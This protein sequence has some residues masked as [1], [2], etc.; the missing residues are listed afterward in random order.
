MFI[1]LSDK[2][3]NPDNVECV[4]IGDDGLRVW[5]ISG[6]VISIDDKKDMAKFKYFLSKNSY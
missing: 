6:A 2:W 4:I 5:L 3:V 1:K